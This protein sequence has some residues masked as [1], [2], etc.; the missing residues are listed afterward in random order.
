MRLE[1]LFF[2]LFGVLADKSAPFEFHILAFMTCI[3]S[4]TLWILKADFAFKAEYYF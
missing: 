3:L 1:L 4:T 2:F